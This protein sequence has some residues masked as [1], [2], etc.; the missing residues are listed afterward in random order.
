[1]DVQFVLILLL[2]VHE[3][4]SVQV[5][6]AEDEAV[7]V[8]VAMMEGA[9]DEDAVVDVIVDEDVVRH[10][11]ALPRRQVQ[12]SQALARRSHLIKGC[13]GDTVTSTVS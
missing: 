3:R 9:A 5:V 11:R 10:H 6:M 1:M 13:F 2:L 8:V 4:S 7:D 12:Q